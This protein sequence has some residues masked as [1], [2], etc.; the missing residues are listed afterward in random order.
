MSA[1]PKTVQAQVD[2]ANAIIDSMNPPPPKLDAEGNPIEAPVNDPAADNTPPPEPVIEGEPAP[3]PPADPDHKYKVLQGKYNAEVPRLQSQLRDA[4]DL[5][6]ELRQRVNNTDSMLASMQAVAAAPSQ[7]VT[8]SLPS[9]ITEEERDQFGPDLIDVI[10]RVSAAKILPE[11]DSRL[12]PV[13]SRMSSMEQNAG[14][15]AEVEA[16][17]NRDRVLQALAAAVPGW[18]TQNEQPEFLT[19]LNEVDV[20]AGQPRGRLL[21]EA[22]QMHDSSRVIAI[23]KGFQT[24]NAVVTPSIPAPLPAEP[25]QKLDDLVAP[26]TPKTGTT[27]APNESG[28]RVWTRKDISG[29]YAAKNEFVKKGDPIPDEYVNLE[30]DLI[31]AQREGRI[32]H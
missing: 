7:P 15:N 20:Y 24:E 23:F 21:T 9:G 12:A 13:D 8:P 28:K 1:L 19:W 14:H 25:Q 32:R 30:K 3:Q 22:F 29:F 6:Q 10:E 18:E 31:K 17:S 5:I 4:G 16:R 11:V 27:S 26:G 2:A